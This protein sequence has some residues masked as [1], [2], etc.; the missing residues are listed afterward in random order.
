MGDPEFFY[1]SGSELQN[2]LT[3]EL[4]QVEADF[5]FLIFLTLTASITGG[6][7]FKN[8]LIVYF[9]RLDFVPNIEGKNVRL[10]FHVI[11]YN[12]YPWLSI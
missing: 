4:R 3:Y 7:Q 11:Q 8:L 5:F 9:E 6:S 2:C 1:G 12:V 10:L